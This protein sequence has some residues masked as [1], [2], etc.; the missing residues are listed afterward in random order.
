MTF[1][2]VVFMSRGCQSDFSLCSC[3]ELMFLSRGCQSDIPSGCAHVKG[4]SK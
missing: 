2:Q 3:Q 4:L 1:H